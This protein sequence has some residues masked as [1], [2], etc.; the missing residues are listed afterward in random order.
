MA[1]NNS[2]YKP[3]RR[4]QNSGKP[5][6][7]TVREI[8]Q[9]SSATT[10]KRIGS[11]RKA[12]IDHLLFLNLCTSLQIGN[13]QRRHKRRHAAGKSVNLH[14]KIKNKNPNFKGNNSSRTSK[15]KAVEFVCTNLSRDAIGF[16]LG[17]LGR[18]EFL[19]LG[20]REA[21]SW[22][23]EYVF[24]VHG[25]R[26]RRRGKRWR[27]RASVGRID[28]TSS[29]PSAPAKNTPPIGLTKLPSLRRGPPLIPDPAFICER[30]TGP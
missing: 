16:A 23:A 26:R 17:I 1:P 14:P 8:N 20:R 13:I 6:R 30:R 5:K 10:N 25:G 29:P 18:T 4:G 2:H 21:S 12:K 22:E 9:E 3:P 28:H 24:G 19:L 15:Q 27:R 7:R 11:Q